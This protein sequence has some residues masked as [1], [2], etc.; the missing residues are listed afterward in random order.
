MNHGSE[1]QEEGEQD[2]AERRLARA[3][4]STASLLGRHQL[5]NDHHHHVSPREKG[6]S[7]TEQG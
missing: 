1:P 6:V 4:V 3:N 2:I 5:R 7:E